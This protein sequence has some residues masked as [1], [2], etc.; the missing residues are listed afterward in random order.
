MIELLLDQIDDKV[1][2]ENFQKLFEPFRTNPFL[3]GDW[4]QFEVTLP[5][6]KTGFKFAHQMSF[7]PKDV[8]VTCILPDSATVAVKY[9][10]IDKTNIVFD[11]SGPVTFRFIAGNMTIDEVER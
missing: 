11:A 6:A 7:T 1:V 10:Q 8:F 9:D 5:I 2:R 4:K 3:S